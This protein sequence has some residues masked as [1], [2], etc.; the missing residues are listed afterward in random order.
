M[1][2][3]P[4]SRTTQ[5]RRAEGKISTS[6]S[7]SEAVLE[8]ARIAAQADDRSLSKWLERL[9]AER[10]NDYAVGNATKLSK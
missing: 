7:L 10:V 8:K 4:P 5:G 6:I 1:K 9:I 2:T 3:T